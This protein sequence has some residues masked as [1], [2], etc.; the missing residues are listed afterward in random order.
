MQVVQVQVGQLQK[1]ET[2]VGAIPAQCLQ[3]LQFF[4]QANC[5]LAGAPTFWYCIIN[6][7]RSRCLAAFLGFRAAMRAT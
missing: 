4:G 1:Q 2:G 3:C 7:V 5:A 6:N